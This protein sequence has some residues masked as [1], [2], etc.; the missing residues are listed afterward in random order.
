L[1]IG[2]ALGTIGLDGEAWMRAAGRLAS[3]PIDRLWVWDHL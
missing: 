3:G 2:V 1:R